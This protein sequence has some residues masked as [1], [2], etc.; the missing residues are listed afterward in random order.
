[1]LGVLEVEEDFVAFHFGKVDVIVDGNFGNDF[2]WS[3]YPSKTDWN[4]YGEG[5][6]GVVQIWDSELGNLFI[7]WIIAIF[8]FF[9]LGGGF[10]FGSEVL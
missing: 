6:I 10:S 8:I 4:I 3:I 5:Y 2:A 1:M 7:S 9:V